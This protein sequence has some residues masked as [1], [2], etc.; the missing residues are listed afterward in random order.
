M[1]GFSD[2]QQFGSE[3][4]AEL[5][6]I[7]P[8]DAS[9]MPPGATE[10]PAGEFKLDRG[11]NVPLIASALTTDGHTPYGMAIDSRVDTNMEFEGKKHDITPFL[12]AHENAELPVM[13]DLIQGGHSA[14]DAYELAHDKVA[15][16]TEA[17]VRFAYAAK[18]NLDPEEFNK[19]YWQHIEQQKKVAAEPSDQERHPDA[20]TTRYGLD[21]HYAGL[22]DFFKSK[23]EP[24]SYSADTSQY[25]SDEDVEFAKKA[26]YSY[27]KPNAG[28]LEGNVGRT[29][30]HMPNTEM[31]QKFWDGINKIRNLPG[32]LP[33]QKDAFA[34]IYVK[35]QLVSD[36]SPI[37]ALGFD[38]SHFVVDK[39]GDQ[40]TLGGA[41]ISR[42]DLSG[43]EYDVGWAGIAYNDSL[44]HESTHR[45]IE[46]L[47]RAGVLSK[48][49]NNFLDNNEETA[50]RYLMEKYAGTTVPEKDENIGDTMNRNAQDHFKE[51]PGA[52]KLLEDIEEKAQDLYHKKYG[53]M[54]HA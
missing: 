27:G 20:H 14:K 50:V 33:E 52:K 6:P 11:H 5:G 29:I 3:F 24:K 51:F 48:E 21:E 9:T 47:R 25:P 17:A 18:N 1:I 54:H 26:G 36:R 2:G 49:E 30:E 23:E 39:S 19:A 43:Q 13:H 37:T 38:P 44:V 22:L 46:M 12:Q 40:L 53:Q 8:K 35:A 34:K 32:V 31:D 7:T 16:P 41:Y 28:Y 15:N 45:G 10:K 42:K 4:E